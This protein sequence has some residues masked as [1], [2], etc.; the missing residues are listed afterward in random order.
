MKKKYPVILDETQRDDLKRLIVSGTAPARKLTHA[1]ILLKADES[2]EADGW[3]DERIAEA[4][5][6]SQPTVS[7]VRKQYCCEG[8]EAALNRRPPNREYH[9]KLDGEQE[10]PRR[11]G[12]L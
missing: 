7:R 3:V 10:A 4:V 11:F 8:L 12:L 1:R 5:E 6:S 9:S 2:T